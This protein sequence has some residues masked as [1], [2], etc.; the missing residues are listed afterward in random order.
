MCAASPPSGVSW[1]YNPQRFLGPEHAGIIERRQRLLEESPSGRRHKR[2]RFDRLR[3]ALEP[4]RAA[5]AGLRQH[6]SEELEQ[7]RHA[8]EANALLRR[9]DYSFVLHPE[10]TLRPFLE[11][12]LAPDLAAGDPGE[13]AAGRHG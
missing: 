10:Q 12:W 2:Q 8:A 13:S 11:R 4:M 5:V 7:A 9:R 6:V 3:A 1:N